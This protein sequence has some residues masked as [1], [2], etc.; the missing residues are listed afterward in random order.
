MIGIKGLEKVMGME[1]EVSTGRG[2]DTLSLQG[3]TE[4][5][6]GK[7]VKLLGI[8]PAVGAVPAGHIGAGGLIHPNGSD[9]RQAL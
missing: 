2:L 9:S 1:A 7:A 3:L 5:L 4:P 8:V 6:N